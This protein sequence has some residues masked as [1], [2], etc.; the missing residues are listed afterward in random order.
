[1]ESNGLSSGLFLEQTSEPA[2]EP[3]NGALQL[4]LVVAAQ[5]I[6]SGHRSSTTSRPRLLCLHRDL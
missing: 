3:E 1:M 6:L 4:H 2:I 5:H